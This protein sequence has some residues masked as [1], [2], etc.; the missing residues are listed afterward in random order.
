M[1]VRI[2]EDGQARAVFIAGTGVP[3]RPSAPLDISGFALLV[4][5]Q[6]LDGYGA[7]VGGLIVGG[8]HGPRAE[9]LDRAW[10]RPP[11]RM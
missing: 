7:F 10:P 3:S 1:T 8:S 4:A 11:P 9:R 5:E 6:G 2:G